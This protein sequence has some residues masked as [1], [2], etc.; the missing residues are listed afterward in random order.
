[1]ES[2]SARHTHKGACRCHSAIV[3]LAS[4]MELGWEPSGNW[5]EHSH[6]P[7]RAHSQESVGGPPS[8]YIYKDEEESKRRKC[9]VSSLPPD[10]G[11]AN[12]LKGTSPSL[13]GGMHYF[14]CMIS[15][16]QCVGKKTLDLLLRALCSPFEAIVQCSQALTERWVGRCTK[17]RISWPWWRRA[18]VTM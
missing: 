11:P 12:A 7:I 17:R 9:L 4:E 5:E 10:A 1:M 6:T 16:L 18:V 2:T 15:S 3:F 8:P 13:G 14:F